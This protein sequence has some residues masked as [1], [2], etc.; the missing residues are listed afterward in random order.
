MELSVKKLK[1]KARRRQV[2]EWS[3]EGDLTQEKMAKRLNVSF[4]TVA[5]D[6]V[7][8]RDE[9]ALEIK[10]D[11]FNKA[12]LDFKKHSDQIL[13]SAWGIYNNSEDDRA[14]VAALR[15]VQREKSDRIRIL[16]SLGLIREIE[17]E[18]I[19]DFIVRFKKPWPLRDVA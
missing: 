8:I 9:M 4:M 19:T 3:L 10:R 5:R 14:R 17:P 7:A 13:S 6:M 2:K 15:V 11:T 12:L 16:Q 1:L 18:A